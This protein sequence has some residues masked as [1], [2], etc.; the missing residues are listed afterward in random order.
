MNLLDLVGN[1]PLIELPRLS[2][3]TPG[4]SLLGKAEFC[5]PSGSVKDRAAK[6][7]ILKG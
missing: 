6:A 4:V 7:M 3:E 1:T 5:N 2:A